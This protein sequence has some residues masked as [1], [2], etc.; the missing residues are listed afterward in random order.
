MTQTITLKIILQNPTSGVDFGIQ[1]GAGNTYETILRQ[2]S[3]GNDLEFSFMINV[4]NKEAD[5]F[6]LLGPIVQGPPTAR[7]IYIDIGTYAGEVDSMWSR[8]LKIPLTGI[9]TEMIKKILSDSDVILQTKVAG[10][11]KGGGPNCGTVKP[12]ES[13]KLS[14]G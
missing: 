6:T 14:K 2:R 7:F 1:K 11:E 10:S 4:K 9:T 8:R 5:T 3:K 12:F 13:W